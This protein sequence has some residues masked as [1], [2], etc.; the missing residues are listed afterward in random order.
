MRSYSMVA[1]A[2]LVL[3]PVLL[4]SVGCS[5][6]DDPDNPVGSSSSSTSSS[7]TG[8]SGAQGGGGSGANGGGG[9][10]GTGGGPEVTPTDTCPGTAVTLAPGG[11][12]T[13]VG[14]TAGATDDYTTFC[15]DT[16]VGM[17]AG[18]VVFELTTSAAGTLRLE[19]DDADGFDGVVSIRRDACESRVAND[20]CVNFATDGEDYETDLAAGTYWVVVDGAN[21]TSGAFSLK[22]S[23]AAPTCGDGVVNE[24]AGE[25]CDPVTPDDT[26]F[27][28]GDPEEC[29]LQPPPVADLETCPGYEVAIAGGQSLV[30]GPFNNTT[31]ADN[32]IGTCAG[33]NVGGRDNV[34]QFAPSDDGTLTVTLGN[35][36]NTGAPWC[37][38]CGN[39]ACTDG[40]G[41]WAFILYAR[42]TA[43]EGGTAVELACAYDPTFTE[44]TATIDF[45]VVGG[46]SYWVVVDSSFAGPYTAGPYYLDA[47]L[48]EN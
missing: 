2:L 14:T 4:W 44:K 31:Y 41:C 43:C 30:L 28:P 33:A 10:G 23:L 25:E 21:S 27:P 32:Q 40:D 16:D 20:E 47:T 42:G 12:V 45:P 11:S 36:A 18:D 13:G 1:G 3:A 37:D 9:S 24:S 22:M 38:T 5:D 17:N 8:G 35:D 15:G 29:T 26:C 48:T 34:F 7:S 39:D 46:T 19:L 6:E